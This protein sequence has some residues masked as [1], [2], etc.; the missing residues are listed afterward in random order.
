MRGQGDL[1]PLLPWLRRYKD[2]LTDRV[3]INKFKGAF[4]WDVKLTGASERAILARQAQ[5]VEPPSPGSVLVHNE[6]EEW[7][8][9]QPQIDA[10]AAEPDGKAMRLMVAAGA[11]VP[12]HFLAE[13]EDTNRATAESMVEPTLRHFGR[14]QRYFGWMMEDIGREAIRR[15]GRFEGA[16]VDVRAEFGDGPNPRV[17]A[18]GTGT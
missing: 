11:G 9:V 17:L 10:Q 4:L 13:A 16:E 3:R 15:S 6:R 12:L 18:S 8:A 1:T 14:R 2:W 5:L 7:R